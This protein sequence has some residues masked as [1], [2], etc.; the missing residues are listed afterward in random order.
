RCQR[1]EI[2]HGVGAAARLELARL[3][4]DDEDRRLAADSIGLAVEV[5]VGHQIADHGDPRRGETIDDRKQVGVGPHGGAVSHGWSR[6]GKIASLPGRVFQRRC[7]QNQWSGCART[8]RSTPRVRPCVRAWTAG[9]PPE[10]DGGAKGPWN[11]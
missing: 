8:M 10:A 6:A 11:E 5:L 2:R 1:A 9:W 4:P 7:T 3:V